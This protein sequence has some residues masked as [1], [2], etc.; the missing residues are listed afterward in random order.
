MANNCYTNPWKDIASYT[1]R[2]QL[3]FKGRD[4]DIEKFRVI[5]SE[6]TFSAIYSSSGIGKTS[7]INAG[8]VPLLKEDGFVPVHIIF[9]WK[10]NVEAEIIK[11]IELA[12]N[13]AGLDWQPLFS[14]WEALPA[15][16][17]GNLR[18]DCEQSLWWRLRTYH[19]VDS[20]GKEYRLLLIFD[21]FEEVLRNDIERQYHDRDNLFRLLQTIYS[22]TSPKTIQT[23]LDIIFEQGFFLDLPQQHSFKAIFSLRKEYLSDFDYWTNDR[24]RI[25]DLLKNRMLLQPMDH[26]Q[27]EEVITGQPLLDEAGNIVEGRTTTTLVSLKDYIIDFIDDKNRNEVEPFL[28][29]V[30][31]SR[32]FNIATQKGADTLSNEDLK[33][34]S[35]NTII[36]EF[37]EH[38][39]NECKKDGLFQSEV[40][41][42]QLEDILVDD[43][44]RHRK[45]ASL[46]DNKELNNWLDKHTEIP[47]DDHGVR[48]MNSKEDLRKAFLKKLEDRHL[49]R[50]TSMGDESFIEIVHDRIA[51]AVYERQERRRRAQEAKKKRKLFLW[52]R[53][54][55][56]LAVL[57]VPFVAVYYGVNLRKGAVPFN[58]LS[59]LQ[60]LQLTTADSMWAEGHNNNYFFLSE[61][62]LVEKF[63]ISDSISNVQIQ[64]CYLLKNIEINRPAGG[65][66]FLDVQGCPQLTD[67]YVKSP[68]KGLYYTL[69]G[70][71]QL[72]V[73]INDLAQDIHFTNGCDRDLTFKI[74]GKNFLW[75]NNVLWDMRPGK[76]RLVY[77]A[78]DVKDTIPFPPS[79]EDTELRYIGNHKYFNKRKLKNTRGDSILY[80]N[81]EKIT[82]ADIQDR[83]VKEVVLGDSVVIISQWAFKRM[84]ALQKLHVNKGLR[85][86]GE[87]AFASCTALDSIIFTGDTI[88]LGD[89]VFADCKSLHYIQL[90]KY[91]DLQIY[92]FKE[93]PCIPYSTHPFMEC[94]QLDSIVLAQGCNLSFREG[95]LFYDAYKIPIMPLHRGIAY[96]DGAFYISDNSMFLR[97]SGGRII[98]CW[99]KPDCEFDMNLYSSVVRF[100]EDAGFLYVYG[101]VSIVFPRKGVSE[102]HVPT[103]LIRGKLI[104]FTNTD[105]IRRIHLPFPQPEGFLYLGGQ[106]TRSKLEIDMTDSIK[107]LITLVVPA[108]SKEYYENYP[109]LRVFKEI[110]EEGTATDVYSS[111]IEEL[112][113]ISFNEI[114]LD[115]LLGVIIVV[116]L[117][118]L[119]ALVYWLR[120]KQLQMRMPQKDV[121]LSSAAF[122]LFVV[123]LSSL[124]YVIAYHILMV[125]CRF[126]GS[127]AIEIDVKRNLWAI[128]VC[129]LFWLL[130]YFVPIIIKGVLKVILLLLTLAYKL[131][132]FGKRAIVQ[133]RKK[134]RICTLS[135]VIAVVAVLLVKAYLNAI[136]P[137]WQIENGN[138]DRGLRL[139]ASQ[140]AK[141]DSVTEEQQKILRSLLVQKLAIPGIPDSTTFNCRKGYAVDNEKFYVESD[142][143]Y[144][145]YDL[146]RKQ[147]FVLP[148]NIKF[149]NSS[150]ANHYYTGGDR[151][152]L[153]ILSNSN[154]I[155]TIPASVS[156]IWTRDDQY[157]ITYSSDWC[158]IRDVGTGKDVLRWDSIPFSSIYYDSVSN[159][160]I[161]GR[162]HFSESGPKRGF[163]TDSTRVS[164]VNLTTMDSYTYD[165][166]GTVA[167]I[168][169]HKYMVVSL[170]YAQGTLL[171]DIRDGHSLKNVFKGRCM[172]VAHGDETECF[173]CRDDSNIYVNRQTN[174]GFV[175]TKI[176]HSEARS[177]SDGRS[178]EN[179]ITSNYLLLKNLTTQQWYIFHL[180]KLKAFSLPV[181]SGQYLFPGY[182]H[183][184]VFS[185]TDNLTGNKY[186][187]ELTADAPVLR[188]SSKT[189]HSLVH[190]SFSK[191]PKFAYFDEDG[192]RLCWIGDQIKVV[193]KEAFNG[194]FFK[195]GYL[196]KKMNDAYLYYPMN[197]DFSLGFV[198]NNSYPEIF[199]T[200]WALVEES[201]RYKLKKL[202]NI[203]PLH[204]LIRNS[205]QIPNSI[206]ESL[207]QK[208]PLRPFGASEDFQLGNLTEV[209]QIPVVYK[210][211]PRFQKGRRRGR[212]RARK[213]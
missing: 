24:H 31:C 179:P 111:F 102:I 3:L 1:S 50:Q 197:E 92:L 80:I 13:D 96:D 122:A 59:R 89:R 194:I 149:V 140:L 165:V 38:L 212:S 87:E 34:L 121:R 170:M 150:P 12:L 180:T 100:N 185:L 176:P 98:P 113:S 21:Q 161:V 205:D 120:K 112:A 60:N 81:K 142:S 84:K 160:A 83:D 27:A 183:D 41:V 58:S 70:N 182:V 47:E 2:D 17:I 128:A 186:L 46:R 94:H 5:L 168:F 54:V 204:Q 136:D 109:S 126:N 10:E 66:L 77:V 42:A 156:H 63:T 23:A 153:Y 51:D 36:R 35:V 181:S 33:D 152:N 28:L 26:K 135:I 8:I 146:N 132:G 206:K 53:V 30:L 18:D 169:N 209:K 62:S 188:L 184:R 19:P 90:P 173:V 198:C 61:N 73:H 48:R 14:E 75:K 20:E 40:D 162:A 131:R 189:D 82:Y 199:K 172:K 164:V 167:G 56:V 213:L 16:K 130:L 72:Q 134:W 178:W 6:G 57:L 125:Y 203:I 147:A 117:L 107:E 143:G 85:Y 200:G 37:Y 79:Y 95:L 175:S 148:G 195:G 7:F 106:L 196:Q 9:H 211:S 141:A 118:L 64:N 68:I 202:V 115:P 127:S 171:Y 110:V 32:L 208:I 88:E 159:T 145:C 191:G 49:I 25:T 187:L 67:I 166:Q 129:L 86:I 119:G 193:T 15:N 105:K 108:G 124:L 4:S 45:R 116:V 78:A 52:T 123:V 91:T 11:T 138:L 144:C 93:Q 69:K 55:I 210:K 137:F 114:L 207:I 76:E 99:L 65:D 104:F 157:L 201:S 177:F 101:G 22:Y 190:G 158:K 29:S 39:V 97:L 174:H 44:D 139:Y 151:N 192:D 43:K 163:M 155:D 74:E 103:G 71:P 133:I 154:I